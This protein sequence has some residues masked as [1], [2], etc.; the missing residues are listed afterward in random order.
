MHYISAEDVRQKAEEIVQTL[1]MWH[2]DMNRVHF[3]RSEGSKSKWVQARI[4]GMGRIWFH[5]LGI[6]PHYVIEVISERYDTST[7]EVK[8]KI[9]IH[10]LLHIPRGFSGGFVCHKRGVTKKHVE[11]LYD[12]L[13]EGKISRD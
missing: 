10:E 6:P 13:R 2:I 12:C 11:K 7:D 5:A 4:H 3:V 9:I 1:G 8:E